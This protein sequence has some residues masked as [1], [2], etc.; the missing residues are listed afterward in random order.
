MAGALEKHAEEVYASF[1][2][3]EQETC[4]QIFLRLVQVDDQGRATKRRLG[5]DEL[6]PASIVSRLTDARLLTTAQERQPTVELAHEALLGNWARL[7]QWIEQDREALRTRR[8]LDEAVVE[9]IGKNRDSAFLLEGGRLAQ[10]EEWA[11]SQPHLKA[12]R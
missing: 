10:V 5:L 2:E 8:R 4:H 1:S 9:W 7:K 6:A 11:E 3:E 12:G